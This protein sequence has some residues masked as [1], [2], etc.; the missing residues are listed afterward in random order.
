MAS[1]NV[2]ASRLKDFL[3]FA[4]GHQFRMLGVGFQYQGVC[5]SF[6]RQTYLYKCYAAQ[7]MAHKRRE[8]K[9]CL[10]FCKIFLR[11][12]C[13]STL[14]VQNRGKCCPFFC[15]IFAYNFLLQI[16]VLKLSGNGGHFCSLSNGLF[17]TIS[18]KAPPSG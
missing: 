12:C 11:V 13:Y 10:S 16:W 17:G 8:R 9:C 14:G 5:C 6:F 3:S 18:T 2:F 1:V 7:D 4:F 15:D